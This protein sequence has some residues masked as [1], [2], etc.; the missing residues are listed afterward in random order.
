MVGLFYKIF[1]YDHTVQS[2][3]NLKIV[4]L[5]NTQTRY[6]RKFFLIRCSFVDDVISRPNKLIHSKFNSPLMHAWKG[7]AILT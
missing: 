7:G 1:L 3:K 6:G 4:I 5:N 2:L